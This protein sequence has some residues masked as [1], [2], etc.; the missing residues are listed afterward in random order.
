[1]NIQK[2]TRQKP[3]PKPKQRQQQQQKHQKTK[4]KNN[5]FNRKTTKLINTILYFVFS[6]L[7]KKV[8]NINR[9]FKLQK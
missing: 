9:D 4:T 1:M 5:D 3:K 2:K 8:F 7:L 6:I